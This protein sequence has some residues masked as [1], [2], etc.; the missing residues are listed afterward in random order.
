MWYPKVYSS[1]MN[2]FKKKMWQSQSQLPLKVYM[3]RVY[4][5]VDDDSLC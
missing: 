5:S 2:K 1:R 3:S 4:E